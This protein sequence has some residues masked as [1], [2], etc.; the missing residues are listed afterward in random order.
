M[1]VLAVAVLI[2]LLGTPAL[3][4]G[5]IQC[6]TGPGGITSCTGGNG[7]FVQCSTGSTGITRCVKFR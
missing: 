5:T 6:S 3:A 4:G 2:V 7:G 1:K